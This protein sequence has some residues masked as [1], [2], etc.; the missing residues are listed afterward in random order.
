M[1]ELYIN[2]TLTVNSPLYIKIAVVPVG[3]LS[4]EQFNYYFNTLAS[5]SILELPE[6]IT[7]CKKQGK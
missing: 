3:N 1:A 2:T 7:F 6:L 4:L 5:L